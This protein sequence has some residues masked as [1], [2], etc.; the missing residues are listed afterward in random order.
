MAKITQNVFL[1]GLKDEDKEV[2]IDAMKEVKLK[3][4][5]TVIKQGDKGD[6]FFVIDEGEIDCMRVMK[7]GESAKYLK[8]YLPGEGFGELAL[9]YNAPRAATLVCKTGCVLFSLDRQTF[10]HVVRDST[11]RMRRR[12]EELIDEVEV[13]STLEKYERYCLLI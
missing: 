5:E 13:L 4:G 12:Y 3:K 10:N 8:T 2:I 1:K 7:Q 9:L 6:E 11:V